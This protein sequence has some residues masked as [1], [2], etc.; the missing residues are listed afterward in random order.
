MSFG[1]A[2][3]FMGT[4]SKETVF[5]LLDYFHKNGGNF[6]DTASNYQNEQ[7]EKW[8]GEWMKARG[9]R[10]EMVI[11]TKFSTTYTKYPGSGKT[12]IV[13]NGGNS[14]KN[15]H[16]SVEASLAKLQTTY[17]DLLYLHWWDY[18]MK[19][20]ELMQSLHRLVQAGKVLY[21][22]ISDTPAWVVSKANEYARNHGLTQFSVYQGHWAPTERS[23]ERDIIP[24]AL[25]EG[26]A[27]APWG[28]IGGGKYK[29][30]AERAD[31]SGR[32]GA[33]VN[34]SEVDKAVIP[35][36]ES[37][38]KRQNTSMT[39]V[40][41]AYIIGKSPYVF[42]IV[43][44]RTVKHLKGNIEALKLK[45]TQEDIKE[46]EEPYKFDPGFPHSFIGS[47]PS[48]NPWAKIAGWVDHIDEIKALQPK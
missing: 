41:L 19:V 29:T 25:D 7:S 13:N 26:M 9:V 42:P 8:I 32:T 34:L 14:V 1:D 5:E 30:E 18:T 17:I 10:D 45:L 28:A 37:V 48:D 44:G 15:L 24:M 47:R 16:V 31:S 27:L 36:L 46:I 39:A 20:P 2:W 35:A 21:L 23:F 43:G 4:C 11:A 12:I 33:W 3:E 6:I 22:G 38:A 40:A